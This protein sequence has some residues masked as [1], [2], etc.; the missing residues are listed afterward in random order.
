MK[1]TIEVFTRHIT[2]ELK[3][4]CVKIFKNKN[5]KSFIQISD[6]SEYEI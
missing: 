1:M 6:S 2:W 4:I 3:K 5:I